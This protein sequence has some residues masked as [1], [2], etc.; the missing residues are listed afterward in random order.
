MSAD[1][2]GCRWSSSS[3]IV[4]SQLSRF[5]VI[6]STTRSSRSPLKPFVA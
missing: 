6:V 5:A 4:D 3:I 1:S 2:T